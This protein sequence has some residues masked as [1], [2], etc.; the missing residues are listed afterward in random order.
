MSNDKRIVKGR[1]TGLV[2]GLCTNVQ[3]EDSCVRP[4]NKNLVTDSTVVSEASTQNGI[5]EHVIVQVIEPKIVES[6]RPQPKPVPVPK[7]LT[8]ADILQ[9]VE[10]KKAQ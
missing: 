5:C 4:G 1:V 7:V 2:F 3:Y 10:P 8:V 6:P 9:H